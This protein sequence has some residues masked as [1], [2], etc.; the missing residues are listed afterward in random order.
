[1]E[2]GTAFCCAVVVALA[3]IYLVFVFRGFQER[4]I[5]AQVLGR[6]V[7]FRSSAAPKE[8][9]RA[10]EAH[11]SGSGDGPLTKLK[12]KSSS[13]MGMLYTYSNF[14]KDLWTVRIDMEGD[15]PVRGQM[16]IS[17]ADGTASAGYQQVGILKGAR[18]AARVF[19]ALPEAIATV[20]PDAEFHG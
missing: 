14:A 13:S 5:T 16:Y 17:N 1:M 3:V 11:L 6:V 15:G 19:E 18:I 4:K 2:P 8:I 12:L 10:V 9:T 7:E 20:D